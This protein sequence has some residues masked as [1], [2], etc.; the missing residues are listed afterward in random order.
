MK[1]RRKRIAV[2]TG[3]VVAVVSLLVG[4]GLYTGMLYPAGSLPPHADPGAVVRIVDVSCSP[5]GEVTAIVKDERGGMGTGVSRVSVENV[6]E[7]KVDDVEYQR[8]RMVVMFD[9]NTPLEEGRMYDVTFA[10]SIRGEA[11]WQCTP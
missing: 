9:L 10:G 2:I 7:S 4:L 5:S 8:G 11:R 3:I 1:S 6:G